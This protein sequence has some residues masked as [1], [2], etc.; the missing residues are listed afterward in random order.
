MIALICPTLSSLSHSSDPQLSHHAGDAVGIEIVMDAFV[1]QMQQQGGISRL[2]NEIL[3]RMC[4]LDNSLRIKLFTTGHCRQSLPQHPGISH[5]PLLGTDEILRPGRLFSSVRPIARQMVA[6][7]SIKADEQ[8]IWHPTYYTFPRD[9][10]GPV[11]VTILDMIHEKFPEFLTGKISEE[12][13]RAKRRLVNRANAIICI[14]EATKR[15]LLDYYNCAAKSIYVIPLAQSAVFSP[16]GRLSTHPLLQSGRP[17]LLYVGG[18]QHYKNFGTL[19]HAYGRW[20]HRADVDLVVVGANWSR[21]EL[22]ELRALRIDGSVKLVS[23]VSDELLR[24]FYLT[25]AAFVYPSLYE[26]FGVPLLEALACGCPLAVSRIPSSLEVAGAEASYFA[27]R[28]TDELLAALDNCL[29]QGR[30]DAAVANRKQRAARFSW[31]TTAA[32]TLS[33][34]KDLLANT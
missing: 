23:G 8:T 29:A 11:V 9:W 6:R 33:V 7:H 25:A 12:V 30:T 32:N 10:R 3:P 1:F 22:E 34:Y 5:Y 19:L 17:F 28:S 4:A 2:Y 16:T 27:P 26:G 24:D 18:R 21:S 13:R 14:S 20:A 15:D 31:D